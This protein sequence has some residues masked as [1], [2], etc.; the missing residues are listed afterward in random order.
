MRHGA[1]IALLSGR[2]VGRVERGPEGRLTFRYDDDW[3]SVKSAIPLSLSMPLTSPTHKHERIEAFLWGL[4]PDNDVILERWAKRFQVSPRNPFGLL[5]HVGEDCAG[6]VQFV[7]PERLSRLDPQ[8]P[9]EIEWIDEAAVEQR[10]ES[11][12][13]DPSAS[14][15]GSDEGQFSLAGAQAK[16]AL[17]FESGR[18]GVPSGRT[19]TTHILKPPMPELDGHVENEHLCLRLARSLGLPTADSEVRRFGSQ[20]AIVIERFDRVRTV[21]LAAAAAM[22]A[23]AAAVAAVENLASAARAADAAARAG[24]LGKL[25]AVQPILRLHQEDLCQ[26]MAVKPALKYENEGGPGVATIVSLLRAHSSSPA[27][28]VGTFIDALLFNWLIAG[29]DGHAKNYSILHGGGGRVRP[30][31]LY[32]IASALPYGHLDARRLK[33][34]MKIGGKYR[35]A[36]IGV[37]QWQKLEGTLG[38][39]EGAVVARG[40]ELSAQVPDLVTAIR[41]EASAAGLVH[42]V[43]ARLAAE[44]VSRARRCA[45]E[46]DA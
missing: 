24:A 6:A 41:E 38:L 9:P 16:T 44:I 8:R 11:L 34:A 39:D 20:V 42:P 7:F 12:L 33:L 18:W 43:V 3:S 27:A 31:P 4:L 5:S 32:D 17:L 1:L 13:R 14:R 29:T 2:P 21:D 40:R 23:A 28:D 25:A 30:A 22:E 46:L 10:L 19:P 26:A 37:H 15:S 36:E 45:H 35:I